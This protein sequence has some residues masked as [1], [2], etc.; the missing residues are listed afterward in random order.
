MS[1]KD[2]LSIPEKM[3]DRATAASFDEGRD[4]SSICRDPYLDLANICDDTLIR[5]EGGGI[6]NETDQRTIQLKFSLYL[7]KMLGRIEA[8]LTRELASAQQ[9]SPKQQT[10]FPDLQS[11]KT[12]LSYVPSPL[13]ERLLKAGATTLPEAISLTDRMDESIFLTLMENVLNE[14]RQ[15]S[16]SP[17]YK[18]NHSLS[19]QLTL[20]G[21]PE[22][23]EDAQARRISMLTEQW[24]IHDGLRMA[25]GK[26]F[27]KIDAE[28]G[29][30]NR[31]ERYRIA[32]LQARR[33][34]IR[35]FILAALG[36]AAIVGAEGVAIRGG[37]IEKAVH[38]IRGIGAREGTSGTQNNEQ[39]ETAP[40]NITVSDFEYVLSKGLRHLD[41]ET[42]TFKDDLLNPDQVT[43]YLLGG[44]FRYT[45]LDNG[46]YVYKGKKERIHKFALIGEK[47][48]HLIGKR[49]EG[50]D[51]W[52]TTTLPDA[53]NTMLDTTQLTDQELA[54]FLAWTYKKSFDVDL[55][56]NRISVV[57]AKNGTVGHVTYNP[58]PGFD[59]IFRIEAVKRMDEV[60]SLTP[61][62]NVSK[63]AEP[64][65]V[66]GNNNRLLLPSGISP[67]FDFRIPASLLKKSQSFTMNIPDASWEINTNDLAQQMREYEASKKLNTSIFTVDVPE[68]GR[69]IPIIL[70][71]SLVMRNNAYMQQFARFLVK[72]LPPEDHAGRIL[73]LANFVQDLPYNTEYD[74][75]FDRPGLVILFNGGS[76]C[77]NLTKLFAEMMLAL[78][79]D[80]AILW[81][82]ERK[83]DYATHTMGGIP[84]KYFP[85]AGQTWWNAGQ[86]GLEHQWVP[87]ELAGERRL[88]GEPVEQVFPDSR[89][90]YVEEIRK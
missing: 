3:L 65:L 84:K 15:Y 83:E 2:P 69:K 49:G 21:I 30:R 53:L 75:D 47:S 61:G 46:G 44:K 77:N 39:C 28:N 40:E 11:P 10:L 76:D 63:E 81:V 57:R 52:R 82:E 33:R 20:P 64:Q 58:Q 18:E 78:G 51:L 19:Y 43:R 71:A 60:Y 86:E 54:E 55:D 34:N 41:P 16:A 25:M 13:R 85:N 73:R 9:T 24:L 31:E 62:G 6:N 17:K 35:T 45:G 68:F 87:I 79:Y 90:F 1:L 27:D 37:Y 88:P 14:R 56:K 67:K 29:K 42:M 12:S 26:A 7:N 8:E 59:R 72:D 4:K 38:A 32:K 74:T 50:K 80:T 5:K 23:A 22:T 48:G 36:L 89:V 70:R 66:V